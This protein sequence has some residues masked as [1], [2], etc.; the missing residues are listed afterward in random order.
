MFIGRLGVL[1]FGL[2]IWAKSTKEDD[3]ISDDIA[4]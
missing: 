4:V 3:C 2:A 1:T